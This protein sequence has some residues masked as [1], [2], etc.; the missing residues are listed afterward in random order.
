MPGRLGPRFALEALFLI[1]V[2]V[3]A[4]FADLS[5]GGIAL[6]MGIAWLLVALLEYTTERVNA[7][8][9]AMRRAYFAAPVPEP[10]VR[11]PEPPVT[12][13]EPAV[14]E[15]EPEEI[16]PPAPEAE[17][18]P[19]PPDP[20]E[21]ATIVAVSPEPEE[22]RTEPE[23]EPRPHVLEPLEPRP[24]RRWFGRREPKPRPDETAE[25]PE[26]A[27]RPQPR[28]VRLLPPGTQRDRAAEEDEEM[29]GAEDREE[30]QQR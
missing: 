19:P 17:L 28:H 2:G 29:F 15:P 11:E 20:G 13:P 6:V 4:G 8:L 25:E 5:A 23:P 16:A 27:V 21:A 12:E 3:G 26:E 7:T 10:A 22:A 24:R 1:A 9:P 30:G 18:E 14:R